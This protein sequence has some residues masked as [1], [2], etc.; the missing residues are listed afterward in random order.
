MTVL[1]IMHTSP[2]RVA[3]GLQ[4]RTFGYIRL[5]S[6]RVVDMCTA[7]AYADTAL[8]VAAFVGGFVVARFAALATCKPAASLK[9]DTNLFR[10]HSK[11]RIGIIRLVSDIWVMSETLRDL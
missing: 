11:I 10:L 7:W 6:G 4:K 8:F 5:A 2:T 9:S 1:P 3:Q